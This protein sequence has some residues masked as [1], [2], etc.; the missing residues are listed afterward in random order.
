[1]RKSSKWALAAAAILILAL[2]AAILFK[3]TPISDQDQ[4][5]AQLA[6]GAAAAQNHDAG[7]IMKLVSADFKG[8][9][10]ISNTDSL[11]LALIRALRNSGRLRITMSTPSVAVAGGT[12]ISTSQLVVQDKESSQTL[13]NEPLTLDW[14]REDGRRLLVLPTKMWRVVG[15]NYQRPLLDTGD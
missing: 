15:T 4:I 2:F 12:A 14:K 5:A 9:Y 7:G 1:M 3:Q 8:P 10:P 6:L 13:F 11:D